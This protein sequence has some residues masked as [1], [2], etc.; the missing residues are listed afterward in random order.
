MTQLVIHEMNCT[1]GIAK[2]FEQP[3]DTKII[4]TS[5]GKKIFFDR[6]YANL[7]SPHLERAKIE[8]LSLSQENSLTSNKF[9]AARFQRDQVHCYMRPKIG[10]SYGLRTPW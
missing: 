4:S 5:H 9:S 7:L 6:R 2:A 3:A 10:Y 1:N 8:A